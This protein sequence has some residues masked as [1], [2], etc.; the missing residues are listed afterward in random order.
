MIDTAKEKG[1]ESITEIEIGTAIITGTQVTVTTKKTIKTATGT[2]RRVLPPLDP[3][4]ETTPI[5]VGEVGDTMTE[6]GNGTGT[7]IGEIEIEM[8]TEGDGAPTAIATTLLLA[9]S[10]IPKAITRRVGGA[11]AITAKTGKRE[12]DTVAIVVGV[13]VGVATEEGTGDTLSLEVSVLLAHL[14]VLWLCGNDWR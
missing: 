9:M 10:T 11:M 14:Q 2:E 1:R 8:D 6:T 13:V 12:E 4:L 5:L 7:M 3:R